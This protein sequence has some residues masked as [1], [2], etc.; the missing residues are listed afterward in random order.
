[1][2]ERLRKTQLAE[3]IVERLLCPSH[4]CEVSLR[5]GWPRIHFENDD[6]ATESTLWIDSTWRLE[7]AGDQVEES[8]ER[9]AVMRMLAEIAG[10]QVEGVT[11]VPDG[12][13][14]IRLDS[15]RR[16]RIDGAPADTD[17][18]EPWILSELP[19][20]DTMG[21]AKVVAIAGDGFAVWPGRLL[22]PPT[23]PA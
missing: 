9:R 14:V 12:G 17:V 15:D 22:D 19:R 11:C 16:I 21:A 10:A 4:V 23:P 5:N 3:R 18:A 8:C 7:S 20:D 6:T 1:M 13:I 2:S